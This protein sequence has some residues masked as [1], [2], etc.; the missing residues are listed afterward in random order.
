MPEYVI[1]NLKNACD[2]LSYISAQGRA[3]GVSEVSKEM[4]LPRTTVMRILETFRGE[5]FLTREDGKYALGPALIAL[6][7]CACARVNV[8]D[9]SVKHLAKLTKLTGETS[10]LGVCSGEKVLIARVCES[11]QPLYATSRAGTLVNMYCSGTGKVLLASLYAANPNVISKIKLEG[12]T[13]NTIIDRETLARELKLTAKRG[14][15]IDD[16]EYHK[17]VRCIAVPVFDRAGRVAA[18]MG[19][20]A[21]AARFDKKQAAEIYRTVASVAEELS[22]ELGKTSKNNEG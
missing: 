11:P 20:T 1:P 12:R 7:D 5:S 10:H 4:R 19:I 9:M 13:P 3:L 8:A 21:P 6:G 2:I 17:G 16:E 15:A 22:K 14:Y 18:A